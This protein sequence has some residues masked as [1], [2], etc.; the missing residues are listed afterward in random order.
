MVLLEDSAPALE[1]DEQ[2]RNP[3]VFDTLGYLAIA[4]AN[5]FAETEERPAVD[6]VLGRRFLLRSFPELEGISDDKVFYLLDVLPGVVEQ[7]H[8]RFPKNTNLQANIRRLYMR[9]SGEKYNDIASRE[10]V[11][12][13]NVLMMINRF[14]QVLRNRFSLEEIIKGEVKFEDFEEEKEI[15][16][17]TPEE[18]YVRHSRGFLQKTYPG[19]DLSDLTYEQAQSIFG[20]I[21]QWARNTDRP[22]IEKLLLGKSPAEIGESGGHSTEH[23]YEWRRDFVA[24]LAKA[25]ALEDL[26]TLSASHEQSEATQK[27]IGALGVLAVKNIKELGEG[28]LRQLFLKNGRSYIL[29]VFPGAADK[30]LTESDIDVF[31]ANLPIVAKKASHRFSNRLR[32]AEQLQ[33]IDMSIRGATTE[34]IAQTEGD[35]DRDS[36]SRAMIEFKKKLGNRF[37]L[38]EI[39]SGELDPGVEKRLLVERNTH[40]SGQAHLP[41]KHVAAV[42]AGS[43][44]TTPEQLKLIH[45]RGRKFLAGVRP[46][47]EDLTDEKVVQV[48]DKLPGLLEQG[49]RRFSRQFVPEKYLEI[50]HMRI[51]GSSWKDIAKKM[52]L[53]SADSVAIKIYE[54]KR[55]LAAKFTPEELQSG[56][57]QTSPRILIGRKFIKLAFRDQDLSNLTDE[58]I[59][60]MLNNLPELFIQGAD[61]FHPNFNSNK[62]IRMHN[63][64]LEG[65]SL[66]EIAEAEKTTKQTVPSLLKKLRHDFLPRFTLQELKEGEVKIVPKE[67]PQK[68]RRKK[69]PSQRSNT[70][71]LKLTP[72][73]KYMGI[74]P[75]KESYDF[76]MGVATELRRSREK[77]KIIE[78]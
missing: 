50:V 34:E 72:L 5:R 35:I 22:R 6:L 65:K 49:R 70:G 21:S 26:L 75:S 31:F 68:V 73:E 11:V 41:L 17:E 2:I 74:W 52:G 37:S 7:G 38:D 46:E 43:E 14:G 36:I 33:R 1:T 54:F 47:F 27:I 4:A 15:I 59:D 24:H 28:E 76:W 55:T 56:E 64:W 29:D 13:H 19:A 25:I 48:I 16:A 53:A 67:K 20:A 63:L 69:S 45:E 8:S 42:R 23:I 57:I 62:Y 10:G 40:N 58:E 39:L 78:D 32:M 12:G 60:S 61:R 77:R 71:I 18:Q 30:E 66:A 9:L 3:E 51:Q 44:L